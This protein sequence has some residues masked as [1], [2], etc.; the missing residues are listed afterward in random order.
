MYADMH[1]N[2]RSNKMRKGY[3]LN[4]MLVVIAVLA[5]TLGLCTKLLRGVISDIPKMQKDFQS[6]F[7]VNDML[8]KLQTDIEGAV[9]LP[10]ETAKLKSDEKTLL[11]A[12][13]DSVLVYYL[14]DDN[15]IKSKIL[16]G[17]PTES[18]LVTKWHIP[19]AKISW[20]TW[21]DDDYTAIE[22]TTY[23]ERN[24]QGNVR[25]KLKNSH[26]YFVGLKQKLMGI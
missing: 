15:V 20:K 11:I 1:R 5:I 7:S 10:K 8:D 9:A 26:V 17:S 18:E 16:P 12:M 4:E 13:E 3:L 25:K 24:I 6:S 23:I 21:G 14:E 2:G 22:V 19:N